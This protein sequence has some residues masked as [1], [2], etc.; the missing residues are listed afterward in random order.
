[1]TV[2]EGAVGLSRAVTALSLCVSPG[3]SLI[4]VAAL[5]SWTVP[6]AAFIGG[7]L[8]TLIVYGLARSG[9]RTEVVTL[10]ADLLEVVTENAMH[11]A[12]VR[13]AGM[14]K[15]EGE[16]VAAPFEEVW[17]LQKPVS[18]GSG[19]ALAGIQQVAAA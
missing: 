11:V 17:N 7:L 5:G 6:I 10:A 15:E 13:F 8:A 16:T 9:G 14:I 4:G 2:L 12:S 3:C 18:G 19:W 1:M